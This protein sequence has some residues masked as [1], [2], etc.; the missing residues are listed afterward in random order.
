VREEGERLILGSGIP[1]RWYE[2]QVPIA[3]GPAATSFGEI[4]L[5]ITPLA[6]DRVRVAWQAD[7]HAA[8]PTL[9]LR[10]PGFESVTAEAGSSCVE[11]ETP[12]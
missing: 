1:E 9:E 5:T 7:W 10:L 6:K 2:P 11:L 3:F 12:N 8:A 4:S